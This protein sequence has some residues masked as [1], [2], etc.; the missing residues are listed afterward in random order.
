[1]VLNH[2]RSIFL[3]TQST[4]GKKQLFAKYSRGQ[5]FKSARTQKLNTKTD[6]TTTFT[7]DSFYPVDV[8]V[9]PAAVTGNTGELLLNCNFNS[10][11]RYTAST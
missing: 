6:H 11:R 9:L 4:L 3:F 8:L 10:K 5:E 7:N 2:F 1:M